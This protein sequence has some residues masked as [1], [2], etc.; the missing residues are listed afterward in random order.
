VRSTRADYQDRPGRTM[1][2]ERGVGA[3][4]AWP[5]FVVYPAGVSETSGLD[6]ADGALADLV[7]VGGGIVG[8][9]TA[10]Q[11]L[12]RHPGRRV[13]VLEKEPQLAE[14]QTGRNSGVLHSGIY[15]KP[16]SLKALNCRRG[17]EMMERFCREQSIDHEICGKVIV[18]VGEAD[19][20]PLA[21]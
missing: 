2:A 1:G 20:A 12:R 15:Y 17:K 8:V 4:R 6:M 13:V 7:V 9:A 16:G 5:H 21:N 19:L 10:W 3:G 14:H 11:L 18:A